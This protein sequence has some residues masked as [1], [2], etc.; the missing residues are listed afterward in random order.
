[1]VVKKIKGKYALVSRN[2]P[3]KVLKWFGKKRPGKRQLTKEERRIRW[4]KNK[5]YGV[6][7]YRRK[8]KRVKGYV[9]S[10]K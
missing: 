10:R 3:N 5:M 7:S 9:R 1:M 4:F 6:K 2:N 8:G